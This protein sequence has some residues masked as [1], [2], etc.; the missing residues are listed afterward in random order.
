MKYKF[1]VRLEISVS[2]ISVFWVERRESW[3]FMGQ[4]YHTNNGKRSGASIL[5]IA[6]KSP[7]SLIFGLK[8][9]L[10]INLNFKRYAV[11]LV[12]IL[13]YICTR[14]FE[15]KKAP[16]NFSSKSAHKTLLKLIPQHKIW[17]VSLHKCNFHNR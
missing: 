10:T 11:V 17:R 4:F 2:F 14:N 5:W 3:L 1:L 13:W 15:A 7:V 9:H 12:R 6:E 16:K 8:F